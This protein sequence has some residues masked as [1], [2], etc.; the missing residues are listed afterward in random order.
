V[1]RHVGPWKSTDIRHCELYADFLP[2]CDLV[3]H[4][5][6]FS[7]VGNRDDITSSLQSL[8]VAG[9]HEL[10]LGLARLE[11]HRWRIASF[12]RFDSTPLETAKSGFLSDLR[13]IACLGDSA[14]EWNGI[15]IWGSPSSPGY[16]GWAFP[17]LP[18]EGR[19]KRRLIPPR[20]DVVLVHGPP[21]GVCDANAKGSRPG[22]RSCAA[23][24][25]GSDPRSSSSDTYTRPAGLCVGKSLCLNASTLDVNYEIRNRPFV[26]DLVPKRGGRKK[27]SVL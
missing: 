15:S 13:S 6:G 17:V 25:N 26:V 9:S 21:N 16:Y 22:A 3:L 12:Q 10:P 14:V 27:C 2:P 8:A 19:A 7:A 1:N 4:A 23:S 18:G 11:R 24:S 5:G 20:A